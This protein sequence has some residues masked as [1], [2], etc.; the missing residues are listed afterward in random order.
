MTETRTEARPLV[1]VGMAIG[2][3]VGQT[4]SAVRTLHGIAARA[5]A[6]CTDGGI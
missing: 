3:A 2:Q 4:E 1:P 5:R 6:L